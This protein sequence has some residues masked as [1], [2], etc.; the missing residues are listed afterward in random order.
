[1]YRTGDRSTCD[2]TDD[3]EVMTGDMSIE[4]DGVKDF[5][6]YVPPRVDVAD[7]E[8]HTTTISPGIVS[9]PAIAPHA[10]STSFA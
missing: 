5:D 3:S 9:S 10:W 8:V 7:D 1:M 2:R 4:Q 6:Q